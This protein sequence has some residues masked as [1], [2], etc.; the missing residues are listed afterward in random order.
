MRTLY[1]I[2][3]LYRI[4]NQQDLCRDYLRAVYKRCEMFLPKNHKKTQKIMGVLKA[5]GSE[6]NSDGEDDDRSID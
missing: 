5:M 2:G 1:S 6:H 4:F 3:M